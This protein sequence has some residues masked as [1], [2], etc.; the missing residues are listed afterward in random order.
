M[1]T[2]Y[3]KTAKGQ[4]E[5]ETRANRLAPRFRSLLIMVDGRRSN[6]EL[7][8]LVPQADSSL[9]ALAEGGYIESISVTETDPRPQQRPVLPPLIS[10]PVSPPSSPPSAPLG[11]PFAPPV[12]PATP[13]TVV[14]PPLLVAAEPAPPGSFEQ[15]RRDAVRALMELCGPMAESLAIRMERARGADELAPLLDSA[16]Q[17]VANTRGRKTAFDYGTRF[18]VG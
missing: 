9:A 15:R 5:I 11:P 14:P 3:R 17:M 10:P 2:I 13:P 6:D 18:K 12:L 8:R 7:A 4:T 1:P 16:I